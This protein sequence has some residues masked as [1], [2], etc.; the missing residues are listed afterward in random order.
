MAVQPQQLSIAEQTTISEAIM[1]L[2]NSWSGLPTGITPQWQM[3]DGTESMGVI[4]LQGAVYIKKD[5]LGGF[6][7]QYPFEV[8]Y[9]TSPKNNK[10]RL[11]KQK[12]LDDLGEWLEA[13]EYPEL[14]DNRTIISIERT[15][16]SFLAG[17]K[18]SGEELY[19]CNMMLKYRKEG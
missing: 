13:A 8:L 15:T 12:V 17:R 3:V 6:T 4:P 10:Q 7:A 16:T 9:D 1:R 19:Q 18:E 2:I 11:A 5:I 14:T